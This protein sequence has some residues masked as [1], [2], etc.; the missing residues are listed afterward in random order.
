VN[1]QKEMY[2]QA[3]Q[4][5][6]LRVLTR[7]ITVMPRINWSKQ[8]LGASFSVLSRSSRT[9][10]WVQKISIAGSIMIY[11][12]TRIKSWR[13]QREDNIYVP[14]KDKTT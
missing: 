11:K 3:N 9:L 5:E 1:C 12:K 13:I 4:K 7:I 6:H 10:L 2:T 14:T 8:M